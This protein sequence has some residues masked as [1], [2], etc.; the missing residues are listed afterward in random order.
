MIFR[1]LHSMARPFLIA[2]GT[3]M[4]LSRCGPG[5]CL[6]QT[7]CTAEFDEGGAESAKG[8][9]SRAIALNA[10]ASDVV[11]SGGRFFVFGEFTA[12]A[13]TLVGGLLVLNSSYNIDT[14]VNTGT[15]FDGAVSRAIADPAGT[16]KIYVIGS[17]LN[18]NGASAPKM[19]R[20][21]ADGTLDTTWAVGTGVGAGT[22]SVL[23]AVGDGS[24]DVYV[25]GNFTTYNGTLGVGNVLRLRADGTRSPAFASGI[26]FTGEVV[27]LAVETDS[28]GD[29][30]AIGDF[31]A[32]QGVGRNRIVRIR[33]NGN[34]DGSFAVGSGLDSAAFAIVR[35]TDGTGDVFVAKGGATYK[36]ASAPD[37]IRLAPNGNLD[38]T[39]NPTSVAG[40]RT[41]LLSPAGDKIYAGGNLSFGQNAVTKLLLPTG[42]TDPTFSIG[43]GIIG[44]MYGRPVTRLRSAADGSGDIFIAGDFRV[45]N[46]RPA[47]GLVRIDSNGSLV[48]A[49]GG[50]S[51]FSE[52]VNALFSAADGS[53]R[54][55]AAGSFESYDTTSV[56]RIARFTADRSLDT[57]FAVGNGFNSFVNDA[58]LSTSGDRIYAVGEFSSYQGVPAIHIAR[59][60]TDG[61][62]DTSFVTGTGFDYAPTRVIPIPGTNSIYVFGGFGTYQGVPTPGIVRLLS[63]GS[64]DP[65]FVS[66]GFG[67]LS[68]GLV[69]NN[70]LWVQFSAPQV[71]NGTPVTEFAIRKINYDGSLDLS[72]SVPISFGF[73]SAFLRD[74]NDSQK[75]MVA[76]DF[77]S[78]AG[79]SVNRI[80]RLNQDGSFDST[81]TVASGFDSIVRRLVASEERGIYAMG[82]FTT[83]QGQSSRFLVK[84]RPDG[85]VDTS[86][87]LGTGF[88][89]FSS[90]YFTSVNAVLPLGNTDKTIA[91]GGD[92]NRYRGFAADFIVELGL[93]GAVQ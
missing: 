37:V 64:I 74:P 52:S 40:V 4:L 54:F 11:D 9:T 66:T 14:T 18:Y 57:T 50:A 26:G 43:A 68:V 15:G 55:Y 41:L 61:S 19:A 28:S 17:F 86:F 83:Y 63:D 7:S 93:N 48:A 72:F 87:N 60:F 27:A 73:A 92:F 32:Y 59:L 77:T 10:P 51:R 8:F 23:E 16:G 75:V 42:A 69:G 91:V 56:G 46:S 80:A 79:Q 62:L 30:Y 88:D 67:A 65:S 3:C 5:M 89:G 44:S 24:G 71:Y 6:S 81:F 58:A 31:T 39:F 82:D 34:I 33:A 35:A 47:R 70:S 20:L 2:L 76:G 84:I 53:G 90:D 45:F 49:M 78:I 36:G 1:A 22:P 12:N 29:F 21:N 85:G 25:A 38:A 13:S